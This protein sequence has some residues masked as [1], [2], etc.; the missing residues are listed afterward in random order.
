MHPE[1]THRRQWL[2]RTF[3]PYILVGGSQTAK[4]EVA[5]FTGLSLACLFQPF[6]GETVHRIRSHVKRRAGVSV[7]RGRR[8]A[9]SS[10]DPPTPTSSRSASDDEE[11][12]SPDQLDPSGT[13]SRLG[14]PRGVPPLV[15]QLRADCGASAGSA[16][17]SSKASSISASAGGGGSLKRPSRPLSVRFLN[18]E[19]A[20]PVPCPSVESLAARSLLLASPSVSELREQMRCSVFGGGVPPD[21]RKPEPSTAASHPAAETS[22]GAELPWY[23]E[24]RRVIFEGTRFSSHETLSQ[25]VGLIFVVS[26]RD[27]DPVAALEELLQ[28]SSLPQMCRQYILDPNPVR[29]VILLDVHL[30]ACAA[31]M[32]AAAAP[33]PDAQ[34]PLAS[35]SAGGAPRGNSEDFAKGFSTDGL[36]AKGDSEGAPSAGGGGAPLPPG[37]QERAASSRPME[38]M[39]RLCE[40]FPPA[41]CHLLTLGRGCTSTRH[42]QQVQHP[43]QLADAIIRSA[44]KLPVAARLTANAIPPPA[45]PSPPK[46]ASQQQHLQQEQA[47]EA[48]LRF[49]PACLGCSFCVGLAWQDLQWLGA[50]VRHFVATSVVPWSEQRIRQLDASISSNRKGLRNQLR[51]LWRKPKAVTAASA[52][53]TAAAEAV[54]VGIAA[55]AEEA[56]G[57]A[58]ALLSAVGGALLGESG[59][60]SGGGVV[61]GGSSDT[62][63]GKVVMG[64]AGGSLSVSPTVTPSAGCYVLHAIEWQYR[65]LGDLSLLFG[66]AE[67]ALQSYRSCATDFKQDKRWLHL[68]AC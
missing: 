20:E 31:R 34:E 27:P 54:V 1:I 36:R 35:P 22:L 19:E 56:G 48:A 66:S 14:P 65:L 23:N 12:F 40:I 5:F 44:E 61:N 8:H 43:Q 2:A 9:E 11:E 13:V 28:P 47:G 15:L 63:E 25:P 50:F 30:D 29:A 17:N 42:A 58:E 33:T 68:G 57:A 64:G 51:Y 38:I 7:H 59:S 4:R 46:P 55:A 60:G 49:S 39:E 26:T 3:A 53:P 18:L 45:P 37:I 6:N 52:T 41:N 32:R 62:G 10:H 67:S 24:W 21:M 16:G